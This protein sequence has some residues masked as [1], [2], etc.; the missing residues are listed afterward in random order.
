MYYQYSC[1]S[2][3]AIHVSMHLPGLPQVHP[4]ST[5]E[6]NLNSVWSG[7]GL[8]ENNLLNA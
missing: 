4:A 6:V 5:Y 3:T 2:A 8:M 7:M 1:Y